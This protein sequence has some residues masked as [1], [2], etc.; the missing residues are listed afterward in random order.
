[1]VLRR[2][3]WLVALLAA[4]SGSAPAR[5]LLPLDHGLRYIGREGLAPVQ[6][7]V[8]LREHPD[9]DFE[10]VQWVEPR[11]WASWFRR[12]SVTR[13]RLQFSNELL[14]PLAYEDAHGVHKPPPGLAPEAI[15]VLA[16][17]LRARA[18]IARG[19]RQA[20][21]TVWN[22]GEATDPWTLEVSGTEIVRT[23]DGT[24]ETLK[25][26]LGSGAEW[27]EGWSAPLLVFH[28]VKIVHWRAGKKLAT[29]ELDD[30]QL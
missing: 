7:E 20:E 17:R 10:Y 30:K 3:C 6:V 16:V 15:D 29:F 27:I 1:M 8:T 23:P 5:D 12:P 24:Y 19:A 28:F 22:G 25:F 13:S 18:D 11:S 4:T 2:V 21:Y 14:V 9:G 26:R